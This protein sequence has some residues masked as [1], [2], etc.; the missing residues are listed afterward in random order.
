MRGIERYD[1][2]EGITMTL[3]EAIV[4]YFKA[5]SQNLPG[6]SEEK[7]EKPKSGQPAFGRRYEPENFGIRRSTNHSTEKFCKLKET[8]KNLH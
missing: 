6:G 2:G 7:H 5:L 1:V 3:T 4:A 8:T